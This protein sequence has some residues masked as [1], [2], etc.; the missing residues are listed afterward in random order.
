MKRSWSQCEWLPNA[1]TLTLIAVTTSAAGIVVEAAGYETIMARVPTDVG[2]ESNVTP[3]MPT[4]I[5][6]NCNGAVASAGLCDDEGRAAHFERQ[7]SPGRHARDIVQMLRHSS[8]QSG[9]RIRAVRPVT[10]R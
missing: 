5:S 7:T 6:L 10:A 2:S 9:R 3:D 1:A 8:L 4:T